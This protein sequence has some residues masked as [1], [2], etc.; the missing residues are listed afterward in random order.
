MHGWIAANQFVTGL[1]LAGPDFSQ[2]KLIQA[3]NGLTDFTAN[4][5]VAPIDWTKQHKDPAKNPEDSGKL[6][7]SNSVTVKN[8]KFEPVFTEPG[9][10][11]VCFSSA[12]THP[13][14]ETPIPLPTPKHYSFAPTGS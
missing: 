8:G 4:G 2:Q 3:L 12:D 9:K 14:D 5:L 6:D 10:P 1:K 11:W 7:C 13:G